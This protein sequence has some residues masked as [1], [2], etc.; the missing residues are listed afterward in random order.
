MTE[1]VHVT[2]SR[3]DRLGARLRN[4]LYALEFSQRIGAGL[5]I[6][7]APTAGGLGQESLASDHDQYHFYDLFDK[8]GFGELHHDVDVSN[9]C[10]AEYR[11]WLQTEGY[12]ALSK[13]GYH[14]LSYFN[15]APHPRIHY[16]TTHPYYF[17]QHPEP[18]GAV[19][20][21]FAKLPLHGAVASALESVETAWPLTDSLCLH[22]R[23]GDI[24]EITRLSEERRAVLN[25]Y[26]L[27]QARH[28]SF[29]YAPYEAYQRAIEE[30]GA[31]KTIVVFSD[32]AEVKERFA[33]DY[34]DRCINYA[35]I[36]DPL[37]LT[38]QQRDFVELLLIS[39]CGESV[40][41]RSAFVELATLISGQK[42]H[43]IHRYIDAD[44][45]IRDVG[46]LIGKSQETEKLYTYTL[47]EFS[48]RFA[49]YGF[50]DTMKAIDSH[51]ESMASS[52]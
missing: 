51:L 50:L 39:R 10:I 5:T 6:N 24:M 41:L 45:L 4:C 11:S 38:P 44:I 19:G 21:L 27:F 37:P 17:S 18:C 2:C 7:W 9:L 43:S 23:R 14:P 26:R 22:V 33:S 25:K 8:A 47:K 46:E 3:D 36:L 35:A 52:G 29:K 15:D 20:P 12:A 31:G 42:L 30:L 32:D 48:A 1:R 13:V 28:F 16:D 49:K 40:G 34:G